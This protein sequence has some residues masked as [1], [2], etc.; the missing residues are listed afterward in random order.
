MRQRGNR[1]EDAFFDDDYRQRYL[2]LLLEYSAKHRPETL[3]HCLMTKHVHFVCVP[4]RAAQHYFLLRF[5]GGEKAS[6]Q[7]LT[8]R[9]ARC[10]ATQACFS[11]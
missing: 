9:P 1:R 6:R 8:T 4:A 5:C 10:R 2:Q 11:L 7:M 3:A